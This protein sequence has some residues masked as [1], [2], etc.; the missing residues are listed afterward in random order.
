MFHFR[1]KKKGNRPDPERLFQY[2][3]PILV[4]KVLRQQLR[5]FE[6]WY[7]AWPEYVAEAQS[8]YENEGFTIMVESDI[9]AYFENISHPLLADILRQYAPQQIGI[10]L[11]DFI[12]IMEVNT[13]VRIRIFVSVYQR[14]GADT[15]GNKSRIA[16]NWNG[17]GEFL[18]LSIMKG[19][20]RII[21]SLPIIDSGI[22]GPPGNLGLTYPAARIAAS[23]A[24]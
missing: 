1:V 12:A 4:R 7:D 11:H 20:K 14:Q 23:S 22:S 3:G 19:R 9:S 16:E 13:M 8:I 10:C 2:Q 15:G 18:L 6:N 24:I 17:H 21:F 5:I